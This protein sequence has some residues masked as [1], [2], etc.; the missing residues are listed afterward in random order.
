MGRLCKQLLMEKS[1]A[2]VLKSYS[3][4]ERNK[5]EKKFERE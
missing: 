3:Q 4:K 2:N 5:K 1:V